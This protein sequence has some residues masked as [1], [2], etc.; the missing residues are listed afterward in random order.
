MVTQIFGFIDPCATGNSQ[1]G[2]YFISLDNGGG[3]HRNIWTDLP[4][5]SELID[6]V[7]VLDRHRKEA[8][9]LTIGC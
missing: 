1:G 3:I 4:M 2:Q 5:P 6:R 9:G 7:H 8:A